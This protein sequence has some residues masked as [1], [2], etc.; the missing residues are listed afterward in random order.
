VIVGADFSTKEVH[1]VRR[2][3]GEMTSSWRRITLPTLSHMADEDVLLARALVEPMADDGWWDGVYLAGLEYPFTSPK[4][5]R[6]VVLKTILGALSALIPAH[7]HVMPM[8][9]RLWQPWFIRRHLS[10][11]LP[12]LPRKSV[13][14]K[15]LIKARAL[16]LLEC[17]DIWPQDAYDAFGISV[18]AELFN[19]PAEGLA[20]PPPRMV[21]P[22]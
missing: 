2:V 9:A 4:I 5:M 8:P 7:V 11:P 16:E 1:L 10:E 19:R 12:T 6:T 13:D 14:R 22:A 18:A 17:D 21:R 3:P 15:P 20:S